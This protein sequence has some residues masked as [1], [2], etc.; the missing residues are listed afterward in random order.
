MKTKKTKSVPARQAR[1]A[2]RPLHK[3]VLTH[4]FSAF[5]MLCIGVLL[6]GSTFQGRAATYDVTATVPAAALTQPALITEPSADQHVQTDEVRVIG[7]CPNPSY[8]KLYRSEVFA[9]ST[10]C[11]NG[12]FSLKVYLSLGRND[13]RARVFN[14]TDVEGPVSSVVAVFRDLPLVAATPTQAPIELRISNVDQANYASGAVR[15]VAANPTVSGLAPPFSDIV[16]TFYSEPSICKTKADSLGRWSCTL[17][18]SLPPGIHHVVVAAITT[19]GKKLTFPTF[20]VKVN[21]FIEP[22]LITSDYRYKAYRS[23]Q[24]TSHTLA[25]AGGTAPYTL[26]IDWGDGKTEQITRTDRAEFS[27]SHLYKPSDSPESNYPVVVSAV[28]VRGA[29]TLLQL[30]TV[31]KGTPA[32]VVGRQ[33][34]S[35]GF[36]SGLQRWLWVVWPVYVAVVLMALSFW[37]G[38]QEAYKRLVARKRTTSARRR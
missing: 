7:A 15:E 5:V 17:P 12:A 3:Q 29:T 37:I 14:I 18:R 4:P 26:T 31:V 2:R 8:V 24:V 36:V 16:V 35:A 9:G 30:V 34:V 33:G 25:L 19:G 23:G 13:L 27:V 32:V 10:T 1:P 38:E 28:D 22:F 6:A 21:E 20:E 11:S